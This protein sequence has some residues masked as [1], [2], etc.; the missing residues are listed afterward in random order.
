LPHND[1]GHT[2]AAF[3][4]RADRELPLAEHHVHE[5]Q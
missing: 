4:W 2:L 1:G 5:T 3:G